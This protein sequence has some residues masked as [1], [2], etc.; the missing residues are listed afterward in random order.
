MKASSV[1]I[2]VGFVALLATA[3]VDAGG[4]H[5]A[6]ALSSMKVQSEMP[7]FEQEES[8]LR[9]HTDVRILADST[10]EARI[11]VA[12]EW[13]G[14]VMTA[15]A[16]GGGGL[17]YGWV[18]HRLISSGEVSAHFNALG[19]E[20]RLWLGPEGGQFS[21]F[22]APRVPFDLEH[23]FVPPALDTKP[24]V[25]V[26]CSGTEMALRSRFTLINRSNTHFDVAV[27]RTVRI[28]E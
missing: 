10:G 3:S 14:R 9:Q 8:F 7:S 23:W 19:G 6:E 2:G 26:R 11:I 25:V 16:D 22:F 20:D 12:P 17:S 21:I 5:G 4:F 13:Q 1:K 15:S 28:L 27:G 18:N 24:F